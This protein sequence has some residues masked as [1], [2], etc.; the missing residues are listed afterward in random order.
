MALAI[1]LLGSPMVE[2][3]GIRRQSP[4]GHKSWALLALLLFSNAPL[5]RERLAGLLFSDAD[6]PLGSLRWN[7]AELRRLLGPDAPLH[8]DPVWLELPAD[9]QIDVRTLTSGTW[10]E[11]LHLPG[12]GREL[13]EG[14]QPATDPAFEAWLLAERR[15]YAGQASA[16][17]RE[18]AVAKLAA[19]DARAAVELGTRLVALDEYD[20]EAHALLIRAHVAAG[21]RADARRYLAATLE[22]FLAIWAS[23]PRSPSCGRPTPQR[24]P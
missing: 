19:G 17:L 22:R 6:D 20:E 12:L 16:V 15:H 18:A 10:V 11:A 21:H 7:L 13:L 9:T 4:R 24:V 8:G 14:I 5:S 2:L 3:D 1:H 23:S